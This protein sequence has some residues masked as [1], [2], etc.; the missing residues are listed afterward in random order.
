MNTTFTIRE[1][2]RPVDQFPR[3]SGR[4][5]F[6]EAMLALQKADEAFQSGKIRQ[7]ILLVEDERGR[8]IGKITPMD[9]VRGLEPKYDR[10]DSLSDDIRYGVPQVV[11]SMK[12]ELRLWQEPLDDLCRKAAEVRVETFMNKP[13]PNQ[14]VNIDEKMDNILHIFVTSRRNSLFVVENDAVVGLLRFSDLYA[15]I[16]EVVQACGLKAP[17]A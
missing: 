17:T 9:V 3:I 15:A 11:Q 2:M 13:E 8:V 7:R 12:E 14:T 5:F 1:L 10:V 16:R 4:S 6:H